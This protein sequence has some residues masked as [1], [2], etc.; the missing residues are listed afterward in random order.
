MTFKQR[1]LYDNIKT[2]SV[3]QVKEDVAEFAKKTG[4]V[5]FPST[6]PKLQTCD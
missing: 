6:Q 3:R 5:L 4:C 2:G 1:I